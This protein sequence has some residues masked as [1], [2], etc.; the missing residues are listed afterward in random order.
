M[1][2]STSPRVIAEMEGKKTFF[3]GVPCK[4]GHIVERSVKDGCCLQC[5]RDNVRNFRAQIEKNI[6]PYIRP[7]GIIPGARV[8]ICGK[9]VKN[10]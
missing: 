4:R 6:R 9:E 1:N 10:R 5:R 2:V 7:N 8:F 3:T